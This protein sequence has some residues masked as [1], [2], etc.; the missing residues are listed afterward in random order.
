L[1]QP[2]SLL[3]ADASHVYGTALLSV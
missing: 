2:L 1:F 3:A